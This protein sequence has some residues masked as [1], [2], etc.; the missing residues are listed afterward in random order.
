MYHT[1]QLSK[2]SRTAPPNPTSSFVPPP[3]T[4]KEVHDQETKASVLLCQPPFSPPVIT[5]GFTVEEILTINKLG[6]KS[7]FTWD[8]IAEIII[9]VR[10]ERIMQNLEEGDLNNTLHLPNNPFTGAQIQEIV[11]RNREVYDAVY[12]KEI[13]PLRLPYSEEQ[14]IDGQSRVMRRYL[15]LRAKSPTT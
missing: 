14:Y 7:S 3:C 11:R 15:N 1:W 10:R 12:R 9:E 13:M 8:E 6:T 4:K 5:S 2:P